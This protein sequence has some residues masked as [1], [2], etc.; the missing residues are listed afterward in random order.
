MYF[1]VHYPESKEKFYI[2]NNGKDEKYN[3]YKFLANKLGD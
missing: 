2:S 3:E 1:L